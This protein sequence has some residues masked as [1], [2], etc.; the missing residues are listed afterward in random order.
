MPAEAERYSISSIQAPIGVSFRYS[1][2]T[3]PAAATHETSM[4]RLRFNVFGSAIMVEDT[5]AGW[6]VFYT[7]NEGKKRPAKDIV[8]PPNID[9]AEIARYLADLCH[10]WASDRHSDVVRVD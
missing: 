10:E 9:E 4:K 8:L 1:G 5:G 6:Q 3:I 2:R 7:G